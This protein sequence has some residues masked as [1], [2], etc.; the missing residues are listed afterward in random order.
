[1]KSVRELSYTVV[2]TFGTAHIRAFGKIVHIVMNGTYSVEVAPDTV[3]LRGLPIPSVA[4]FYPVFKY[5][6]QEL[7]GLLQINNQGELVT[8]SGNKT[9]I[10]TAVYE[11]MYISQ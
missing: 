1:M 6:T 10:H 3:L 4:A 2:T 7:I 11:V 9:N 8:Y 5:N